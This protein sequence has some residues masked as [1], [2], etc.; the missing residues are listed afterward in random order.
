[1]SSEIVVSGLRHVICVPFGIRT[2]EDLERASFAGIGKH[3]QKNKVWKTG[4]APPVAEEVAARWS[5]CYHDYQRK[6]YFHR[7][8]RR[9]MNDPLQTQRFHRE[10]LTHL[11]VTLSIWSKHVDDYE[12]RDVKLGIE[13]CELALFRPDIAV[14]LL[15]LVPD[16][17]ALE[18]P[19]AELLFDTLRRLYPPYFDR[20][21]LRD[22]A[23]ATIGHQW[24]NRHC[25]VRV[26]LFARD[27][28][29][30]VGV[31]EFREVETS[32][33]Q[34][35]RATPLFSAYADKLLDPREDPKVNSY[36]L[37]GHWAKL[38]APFT[39]EGEGAPFRAVLLGDDRAPIINWLTVPEPRTFPRGD[40]VRICFAD[41]PGPSTLPYAEPFMRDFEKR[42]CYDR[43][44]YRG[45]EP[46]PNGAESGKN[47]QILVDS[48]TDP[49]RI[50]NSGYAFSWVGTAG[51]GYFCNPT[52]GAVATFRHIYVEMGVIAHFHKAALLNASLR[53][54]ELVRRD[55][56]GNPVLPG[57][58]EVRTFYEHFIA[59]TQNFWFE[60][61]SP[62]EQGRELFEKWRECL[63]IQ[64]LYD[65]VRQELKDLVDYT[66]LR[67]VARI[68]RMIVW[69]GFLGLVLAVLSVVA[70]VFTISS[71]GWGGIPGWDLSLPVLALTGACVLGLA[72]LGWREGAVSWVEKKWL[73]K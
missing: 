3:L 61:I 13:R 29:D 32:G 69:L 24:L 20:F 45:L 5:H 18:L 50:V 66:E 67:A 31:G 25:P 71:E 8:V 72:V 41:D 34:P 58:R 37:A 4:R 47:K 38:L 15:E 33:P 39:D 53:L 12:E 64:P 55:S 23:K 63:G 68:N 57:S 7:F 11:L 59:F 52:N 54:S 65:E 19:V 48:V 51:D 43:F 36:C 42:F 73:K 44:F 30:P 14:L 22:K 40:W 9:F 70:T 2:A 35:A 1:M 60:E 28:G 16:P 62:Q 17:P 6:A 27:L 46:A 21:P 49:S 10:D 26:Q 56:T